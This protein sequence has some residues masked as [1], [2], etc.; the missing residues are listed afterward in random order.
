M[1]KHCGARGEAGGTVR[2]GELSATG[3]IV[4]AYEAVKLAEQMSATKPSRGTNGPIVGLQSSESSVSSN[5][6]MG[7]QLSHWQLMTVRLASDDSTD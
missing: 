2:F 5:T 4:N 1:R 6:V 7:C 3:A